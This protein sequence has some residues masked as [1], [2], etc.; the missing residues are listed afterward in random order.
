METPSRHTYNL[1]GST[2]VFPVS[3]PLKGDNY[4]RVEV[5]SNIVYDRSKYDIVN[6]SIVFKDVTDVPENSVLDVLVVQSEEAIGQ[7]GTASSIDLVA[8]DLSVINSVGNYLTSIHTVAL[9]QTNVNLL[10][11]NIT[12]LTTLADNIDDIGLAADASTIAQQAATSAEEYRDATLAAADEVTQK[13]AA[14]HLINPSITTLPSG[15]PATIVYEP[16]SGS[17]QFNIPRGFQGDQ[18]IQGIQGEE[19]PMGPVGPTG[20]TGPEGQRGPQGL[21]G[22]TGP[23]GLQG[24]LGAT[25]PVG[26][27]GPAGDIGPTGPQGIQGLIGEQGV[28]GTQGPIGP[29]GIQGGVGN[30]GPDGDQGP[31]GPVGTQGPQGPQGPTSLGL[32]FGRF[33][34]EA[35][36]GTLQVEY[37]G[38]ADDHDFSINSNGELEVII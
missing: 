14:V 23:Q 31:I 19:G 6:N 34:I 21:A 16:T 33:S 22:D 29:Q 20:A 17:M 32:A 27:Q 12:T 24:P 26:P 18:G 36:T 35:S 11:S 7:L 4:C 30:K 13:A 15:Q 1:D 37:Y 8:Q 3:S 5:D 10:G 9:E 25:G 2:L 38:A 28:Q